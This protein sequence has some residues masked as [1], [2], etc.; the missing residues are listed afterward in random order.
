MTYICHDTVKTNAV[1]DVK[2]WMSRIANWMK[3]T[4]DNHRLDPRNEHLMR[5]AG[6]SPGDAPD[7]FKSAPATNQMP[8]LMVGNDTR[9]IDLFLSEHL[10]RRPR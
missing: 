7:A 5:D 10:D 2:G 1:I 8:Y 4:P 3:S 9:F 6:I